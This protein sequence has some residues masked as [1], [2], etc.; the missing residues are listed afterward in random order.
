[1]AMVVG[2][3]AAVAAMVFVLWHANRAHADDHTPWEADSPHVTTPGL[4]P[5]AALRH[6]ARVGDDPA[7]ED[8]VEAG[9]H[10]VRKHPD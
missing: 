9:G 4:H 6:A 2:L 1:M 3:A 7:D 10:V 5:D 8:V